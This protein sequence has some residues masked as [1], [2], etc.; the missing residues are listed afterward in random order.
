MR[1]DGP[2]YR[3]PSEADSLLVQATVGCPHN[4][5]TFCMVYKL[6]VKFKVKPVSEIKADL[7]EAAATFSSKVGTIFFPA[8]N[9]IAMPTASLAE[10][11]RYSYTLFPHLKRITVYG[12]S[13]YIRRKRYDELNTLAQAGLKRIHVGVESGDDLILARIRK[14]ATAKDHIV[15]G[16]L[17]RSVGISVNAYVILGIGGQDRSEYHARETA[18]VINLMQPEV[19]RLRTFVPKI[20]TPLLEDVQAGRFQM[21]SPHQVLGEILALL[22]LITVPTLVASDHYTN[23]LNVAGR[24]PEDREAMI[25]KLH[26][27]LGC[28]ESS[29]RPFFIGT[30]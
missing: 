20:N 11:C 13:Q 12:S 5:C 10:I 22:S 25:E 4:L 1:Y 16:Q 23:Y 24:L 2:I 14:G 27:A 18:R 21:L 15:A 29:F 9:T 28:E 3:P 7:E 19:V 17:A 6:G 8:G 30:Q 26:Q